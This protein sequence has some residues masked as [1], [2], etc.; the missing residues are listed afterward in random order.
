MIGA[1]SREA[2]QSDRPRQVF[3][4]D[5]GKLRAIR[6]KDFLVRFGFGF[7]V[8]VIAAV[9]GDVAGARIGGLFLAFPAI[10]PATLTLVERKEGIAQALS[11]IR[12]A[13]LGAIG[14]IAFAVVMVLTVRHSPALA[15]PAA[16]LGWVVVSAVAYLLL[17]GLAKGL[18][19]KQYLPE[20][21]TSEAGA[22]VDVLIRRGMSV[23]TAES[24]TGGM[25]AALLSS[26]PS[27]RLVVRASV[28]AYTDELKVRLLGV[29]QET[30]SAHGAI[31]AEVAAEMALGVQRDTGADLA[32][33]TTG[34]TGAAAA[35]T[36]A[37]LTFIAAVG[38]TLVPT[39]RR[40][41]GDLGPGRNDE[42]AVRMALQLGLDI[43][44]GSEA[45]EAS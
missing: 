43:A 42:R 35:G 27:A 31:S 37:G 23:A 21:P 16:L 32:I 14:M 12:G 13:T 40:Y 29:S 7:V 30:L 20:I 36:P 2:Q 6:A 44:D 19:E 45:V 39:V 25:V 18:R 15:V 38:G 9:I 11:D 10:L 17:R 28:T 3:Q 1:A 5:L 33:A 24:C 8:S 4:L 26:V 41:T 22:L 34:T